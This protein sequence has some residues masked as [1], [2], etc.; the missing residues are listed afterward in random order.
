[1]NA[2]NGASGFHTMRI[3]GHARKRTIHILIDSRSP[4]NFL[5]VNLA[6]RFG[7]KMETIAL[8]AV[9]IADG[10]QLQCQYMC[11]NFTWQM[12]VIDFV[13]SIQWL[14]TLGTIK[15]NFKNLKMEFHFN[16]RNYI[17]R[18][19]KYEKIHMITQ[20]QLP[21]A[22]KNATDLWMLQLTP[23]TPTFC[24]LMEE[25]KGPSVPIEL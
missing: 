16:G 19:L 24:C 7:C 14:A 12:H 17:L 6:K 5:D 9:T 10:S 23:L 2:M 21:K 1:M 25:A 11:K 3:N 22:L 4:H 8:Q 18:R 13:L 20:E 15:W